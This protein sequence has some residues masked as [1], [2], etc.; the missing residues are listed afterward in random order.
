MKN[1]LYKYL[2]CIHIRN[3]RFDIINNLNE[4]NNKIDQFY[5]YHFQNIQCKRILYFKIEMIIIRNNK[6][7]AIFFITFPKENKTIGDFFL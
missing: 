4:I 5:D 7:V 3:S 6:K 1:S 2:N